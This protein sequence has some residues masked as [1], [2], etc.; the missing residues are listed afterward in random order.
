MVVAAAT[1]VIVVVEVVL[2]V[3]TVVCN[4]HLASRSL[5]SSDGC[6]SVTNG[7]PS[8]EK[9]GGLSCSTSTTLGMG[10]T[11]TFSGGGD[12]GGWAVSSLVVNGQLAA[13]VCVCAREPAQK[14]P[15]IKVK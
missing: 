5:N 11:G 9:A 8:P 14:Q 12:G 7:R 2:I 15:I 6:G 3:V 13:A 4:V 10:A 1:V